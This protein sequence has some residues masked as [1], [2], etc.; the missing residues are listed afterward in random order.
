MSLPDGLADL[1][2][3][4]RKNRVPPPP[5]HAKRE[6]QAT[7]V[8]AEA[9]TSTVAPDVSQA[10]P[11]ATPERRRRGPKVE[12]PEPLG[13]EP[14]RLVQ[15]YLPQSTDDYLRQVRAEALTHRRDVTASAAVRYAMQELMRTKTPAQLV[16]LLGDKPTNGRRGRSRR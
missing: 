11:V 2:N 7:A 3:K 8:T 6:T 15:V 16:E 5:R 10:P 14:I 1:D 4:R 9:P 13:E 12:T